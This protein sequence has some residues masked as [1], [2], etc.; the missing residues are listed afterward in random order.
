MCGISGIINLNK[1]PA[2]E[3]EISRMN[4]VI[5]HRGPD[6]S[7]VY[8]YKNL[9][10]GHRRLSIIDLSIDGNQPMHYKEKYTIIFNGEI[11]NYIEIKN[12]LIKNEYTFKT[13]SDTEVIL[14][15]YDYWGEDCVSRFNG[16]WS[17]SILDKEKNILFISR[18]RFG[19]K[20]FYYARYNSQFI[21]GS[22]I[23]QILEI[24]NYR[25]VNYTI[26]LDYLVWGFIDHTNNTFFEGISK[27]APSHNLVYD[28]N[29]NEYQIKK[30]F[31]IEKANYSGYKDDEVLRLFKDTLYDAVSLRLRSDV[32]V[33][34]C[35][36]G[37]LDSS[38]IAAIAS[39]LNSQRNVNPFF[40]IH[41]MSAEKSTDESEFAI[42]VQEYCSLDLAIV[43]PSLDDFIRNIDEVIYTQEEPFG[44]LSI[45]MQYF[46]MQESR[47]KNCV[48]LLDGQGGDEC[49]LGYERYYPAIFL[50]QRNFNGI[51]E[52][53][54]GI[55]NSKISLIK[56]LG[57]TLYFPIFHLRKCLLVKKANFIKGKY[58]AEADKSHLKMNSVNYFNLFNLQRQEIYSTQLPAL[59]RYEDKNSMRHSIEARLPFLDYRMLQLSLSIPFWHKIKNG[60]TKFIL[61]QSVDSLLPKSIVWRKN[62][63]G[64]EAPTNEWMKYIEKDLRKEIL[65]SNLL[66][67][68]LN[69]NLNIEKLDNI[70]KWRLYN[71]AKW[72]KIYK[73]K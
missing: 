36:S 27:L 10:I 62:K 29:T 70:Q 43:K 24:T 22:E 26:L 69:E 56:M 6:A 73:L 37:G 39:S 19:V 68:I 3:T 59:L 21:F 61:R 40:A 5:H 18:D 53:I 2:S 38:S 15:A 46:V 12:E 13:N 67:E 63:K 44:G 54:K 17:F 31:D 48:V 30:Y 50:E 65:A 64:F 55:R 72:E 32:K 28:L 42:Q 71:V 7:Q 4:E 58:I 25:K 11:Y 33:G 60:W 34:T 49:L 52:F 41:A 1:N 23:K 35:L 16:M 45:Y 9:G 14:C 66:K 8:L 47:K 57:F 20:P 51:G